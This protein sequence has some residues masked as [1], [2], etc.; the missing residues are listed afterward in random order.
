M[1]TDAF[2]YQLFKQLQSVAK[3]YANMFAKAFSY[4]DE[5]DPTQNWKGVAIFESRSIEPTQ[6]QP[7]WELLQSDRVARIY[8]DEFVMPP[9]PPFGLGLL[10]LLS[11]AKSQIREL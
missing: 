2:F 5:N 6:V 1:E 3:F 10:Q 8:L 4:L 7:Y 9:D 11:A